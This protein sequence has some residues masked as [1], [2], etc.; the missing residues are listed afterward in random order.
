MM[1]TFLVNTTTQELKYFNKIVKNIESVSNKFLNS[2]LDREFAKSC[3]KFLN[4][5][6][7]IDAF[8]DEIKGKGEASLYRVLMQWKIEGQPEVRGFVRVRSMQ[9]YNKDT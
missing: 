6:K 5:L 4:L 8:Y 9:T 7:N 1:I 3:N 2:S